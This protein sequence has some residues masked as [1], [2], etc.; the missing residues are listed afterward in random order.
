MQKNVG[1]DRAEAVAPV[2]PNPAVKTATVDNGGVTSAAIDLGSGRAVAIMVD[3]W[4]GALA[5]D[6][7]PDGVTFGGIYDDTGTEY[8]FT[9][10][11]GKFHALDL[12]KFVGFSQI[13]VRGSAQAAARAVTV[14]T[15]G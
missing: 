6:G 5:F 9:P 11:A 8:T 3:G 10:A 12:P 4:T 7:S 1:A 14:V 2:N 13:K 15:V